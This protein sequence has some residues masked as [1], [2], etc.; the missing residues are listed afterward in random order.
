MKLTP[1]KKFRNENGIFAIRTGRFGKICTKYRRNDQDDFLSASS[2]EE[3]LLSSR[4]LKGG[5][6]RIIAF[7][8]VFFS[9]LLIGRTAWLQIVK[10]DY[11]LELAEG[12]RIRIERIDAKRGVIY[13]RKGIPLVRNVA[14]FMLYCIPADIPRKTE[15]R[16]NIFSRITK[17]LPEIDPLAAEAELKK[18]KP[19]SPESFEPFFIADNIPYE[20]AMRLYLESEA[21]SGIVLSSRSRR[22][23]NPITPSM[24]HLLGYSGKISA[25]ELENY[26][27]LYQPI[28]Y[29]GKTGLEYFWENHLRGVNGKKQVEVDALGKE[30]KIVDESSAEDGRN[31]VLSIDSQ[32]QKKL[33]ELLSA[34]IKKMGLKKGVAIAQNPQNGEI[35]AMVAVPA[36]DNNIFA[37]GI[38]TAEYKSILADK[39]LPMFNRAVSG[40]YPSGSTIKPVIAAAALEERVVSEHTAFLSNG[41]LKVG[42]WFFPDW[43]SGGHGTTDMRKALAQSV[44][45]YFYCIGGGCNDQPGLGVERIVRYGKLF[46]LGQ[47]TGIDLP[48]EMSGFL[49]T[50]EWKEKTKGEKWYIGDT[51]HLSIGQGD[52][53]AT[54]L[55]I[56]AYTSFFAN[57]G[58]LYRPHLVSKVLSGE[59]RIMSSI[60]EEPVR[61]GF[62]S[63]YNINVVREG[64]RQAV[65]S[66]SAKSLSSLTVSVA[67]K[68][69]TAQWSSN[70][71]PHAWFIG[72][73]PYE[74]PKIA[75]TILIEEGKEGSTAAVP[76][77]KDF[78][79][80]YFSYASSSSEIYDNG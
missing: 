77:A 78:L 28:D 9:L 25:D 14:N 61:K 26:G 5:R 29:V 80:W 57:G 46:G 47:E 66:G 72:F 35:I 68:T 76:V 34:Q 73:A 70:K 10:G 23:Y 19:R 12:N 3:R 49:P 48:G 39:D 54:P 21:W 52:L 22:S 36:Y 11:Y 79:S 62:I 69:G 67:G 53:L 37:R 60:V 38:S 7:A 1:P 30:K 2:G 24:S 50:K 4:T 41:G 63:G 51:Y 18:I 55:Q 27:A 33:E 71:E 13:D 75:L 31:L 20:Q 44:N 17:I 56:S 59:D 42:Q 65:T 64:M 58:S 8:L 40:E 15:E 32:V 16:K 43:R 45:T 74:N 6:F